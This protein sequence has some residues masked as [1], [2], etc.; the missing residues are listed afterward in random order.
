[1]IQKYLIKLLCIGTGTINGHAGVELHG[2]FFKLL[3]LADKDMANYI[4]NMQQK[5][6]SIGPLTGDIKRSNGEATVKEGQVYYFSF[7][8]IN[9]KLTPLIPEIFNLTK[10]KVLTIGKATFLFSQINYLLPNETSFFTI[11]SNSQPKSKINFE[12]MSPTCFRS[13]NQWYLF[14]EPTMVF[15]S[16]YEKWNNFAD[17]PLPAIDFLSIRVEKYNLKTTMSQMGNH[18]IIGF[19]GR[20]SYSFTP[21]TL[22]QTKWVVNALSYFSSI[23]GVGYKS[24]MGMGQVKFNLK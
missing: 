15:N 2:L 24:T 7:S 14:P 10:D 5:P 12:F 11:L 18:N 17:A 8:S 9:Y 1:M 19:M 21:E 4:H 16:L 20:C 3:E 6:F 22:E 23:I 13:N